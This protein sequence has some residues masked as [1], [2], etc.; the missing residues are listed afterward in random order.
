MKLKWV[1]LGRSDTVTYVLIS[2]VKSNV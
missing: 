1:V 2:L